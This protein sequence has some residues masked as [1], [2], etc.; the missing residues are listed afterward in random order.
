MGVIDLGG[1]M[2]KI[3]NMGKKTIS[4]LGLPTTYMIPK[5]IS[6]EYPILLKKIANT[7]PSIPARNRLPLLLYNIEMST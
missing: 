2:K 4:K 1:V 6:K 7:H 5:R 3:F